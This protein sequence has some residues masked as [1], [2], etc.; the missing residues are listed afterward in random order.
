MSRKCWVITKQAGVVGI[1]CMT[2]VSRK[3]YELHDWMLAQGTITIMMLIQ[4]A[5]KPYLSEIKNA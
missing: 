1:A 2:H 5:N 3:S 4:S